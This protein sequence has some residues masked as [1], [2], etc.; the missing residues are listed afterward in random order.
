MIQGRFPVLL[1][2]ENPAQ[3]DV[4][5]GDNFWL[6]RDLER[7]FEVVARTLDVAIHRGHLRQNEQRASGIFAVFIQRL[8][9]ELL[10]ALQIASREALLCG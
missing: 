3:I 5:P 1:Q 9:G 7:A 10:C 8:L 6:L 2:V 4:R